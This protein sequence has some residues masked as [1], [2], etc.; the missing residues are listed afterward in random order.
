M[1][2]LSLY[3][4]VLRQA[5][6][7]P[8]NIAVQHAEG[9]ITY[10]GLIKKADAYARYLLRSRMGP[11]NVVCML[12]ER[13]I[14]MIACTIGVLQAGGAYMQLNRAMPGDMMHE[15]FRS[16]DPV[17]IVD[18]AFEALIAHPMKILSN[19]IIES[20][21]ESGG[22]ASM[23]VSIERSSDQLAYLVYTTGTSGK[24]KVIMAEDR[25][26]IHYIDRYTEIFDITQDDRSLQQSPCYYDRFSEE[27]FSM[28]FNGGTI[29]L[30]QDSELLNPRLIKKVIARYG[31]TIM[32]IT[33]LMLSAINSEASDGME[34]MRYFI[35]T[36][37]VLKLRQYNNLVKHTRI[38]NMYGPSE[39]TV[40]ATYYEC[41]GDEEDSVP[42]GKPLGGYDIMICDE[43]RKE[44][45]G[46]KQGEIYIGGIGITRGYWMDG[47]V[48]SN[49]F[50]ELFGK[51]M[52]KTN[53]I[54]YWR[55][56]G[57][58][59]FCG[60]KDRQIKIHGRIV[61]IDDIEK[62]LSNQPMV[63]G[64][65]I[66]DKEFNDDRLIMAFYISDAGDIARELRKYAKER[67]AGYM[68]PGKFIRVDAFPLTG[69]GKLDKKALLL[70]ESETKTERQEDV[71]QWGDSFFQEFAGKLSEYV[72][73]KQGH[74]NIYPDTELDDIG[75]DSI[76]FISL[77]VFIESA[78]GF[79]FDDNMLDNNVYQTAA[80]LCR[81]I[82]SKEKSE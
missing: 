2:G 19:D 80:D 79:K 62:V 33:P 23:P 35:S 31:V 60:R 3:G 52:F 11:N 44:I 16:L 63:K 53:D 78:Y 4:R 41:K 7:T 76:E 37:D 69:T 27:V 68:V 10:D 40:C 45:E 77:V 55:S 28:L 81:Y 56:D 14:D 72:S 64:V 22:V 48:K 50:I 49:G 13:S 26:I 74:I 58:L 54:G 59:E 21:M 73:L 34:S 57:N 18:E 36:G 24:Q 70:M 47:D 30:P 51:R 67:L 5:K 9:T 15:L 46:G 75:I 12:M 17:I 25:N 6:L 65:A 32:G 42:V 29:I 38:I 20:I 66:F 39:T 8:N 61:N 71:G 43:G 1:D 82:Q